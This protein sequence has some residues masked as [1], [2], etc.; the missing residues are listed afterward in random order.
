MRGNSQ[1]FWL[2]PNTTRYHDSFYEK[3]RGKVNWLFPELP[4]T[5]VPNLVLLVLQTFDILEALCPQS[6]YARNLGREEPN[7][8]FKMLENGGCR[9][10]GIRPLSG[11]LVQRLKTCRKHCL[12]GG[13]SS[14]CL[15]CCM[16][17]AA[18][19][20]IEVGLFFRDAPGLAS[21]A[22]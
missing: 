12:I 2:P 20:G 4:D 10:I 9:G 16:M 14:N 8:C 19:P 15:L 18:V 5:S 7:F 17:M 1:L 11:C 21:P 6:L 13:L 22:R 3:M